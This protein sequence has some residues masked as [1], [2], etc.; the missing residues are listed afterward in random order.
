VLTLSLNDPHSIDLEKCPAT[1]H[2]QMEGGMVCLLDFDLVFDGF[3]GG[4]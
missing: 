2:V 1:A 3:K 4:F